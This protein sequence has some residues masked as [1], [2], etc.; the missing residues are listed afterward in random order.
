MLSS[1]LVAPAPKPAT[2]VTTAALNLRSAPSTTGGIITTLAKGT[3]VTIVS[4]KGEWRQVKAASR[5]GWVHGAYL[6]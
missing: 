1:A 3:T 6:R 4:T 5:T 2:K